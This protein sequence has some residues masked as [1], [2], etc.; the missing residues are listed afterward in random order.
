M[1]T[2]MKSNERSCGNCVYYETGK[3]SNKLNYCD[4]LSVGVNKNDTGCQKWQPLPPAEP[5][6]SSEPVTIIKL[7]EIAID[8][9]RK[10]S[11]IP[12][13]AV[14]NTREYSEFITAVKKFA[15]A[16]KEY[17]TSS[18]SEKPKCNHGVVIGGTHCEE[19]L[20]EKLEKEYAGNP[21]DLIPKPSSEK[22]EQGVC[23]GM[24]FRLLL[25]SYFDNAISNINKLREDM[26]DED[27]Y[28][29]FYRV[30]VDEA[31]SEIRKQVIA[32]VRE[33][34]KVKQRDIVCGVSHVPNGGHRIVKDIVIYWTD[35][36]TVLSE[37]EK[38][39]GE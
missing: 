39:V 5:K 15:K 3:Y 37:S 19:C 8:C 22:P 10:I 38:G 27:E 28:T 26:I 6:P 4:Y 2:E 33:M 30:L 24:T 18:E 32:E 14:E 9:Y 1:S 13:N 11:A 31:E 16:E 36:L 12:I 23:G 29:K 34:L 20:D 25:I 35:I 7:R 17:L 21:Q